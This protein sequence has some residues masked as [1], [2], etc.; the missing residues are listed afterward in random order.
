ML[1]FTGSANLIDKNCN[2]KYLSIVS[3]PN[4]CVFDLHK[5]FRILLLKYLLILGAILRE[6][7]GHDGAILNV[8]WHHTNPWLLASVGIDSTLRLW[9]LRLHPAQLQ[10]RRT[11]RPFT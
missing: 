8:A 4:I 11:P 5:G 2:G 6:F 9:D 1:N 3:G 10:M 7:H